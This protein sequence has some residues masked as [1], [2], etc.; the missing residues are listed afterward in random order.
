MNG[1]PAKIRART[2]SRTSARAAGPIGRLG[3]L[4][5][6]VVLGATA[7][8]CDVG[9]GEGWVRSDLLAVPDCWSG[10]FDLQPDFFGTVPYRDTQQIRIQRG[11]DQPEVSDG[12]AIQVNATGAIREQQLGQALDVG[13]SPELWSD[14][15]PTAVP[16]PAPLVNLALY[17]QFSCHNQNIVLYGVGGTVTFSA[18]FSGDPIESSGSEKLTEASFDVQVADPRDAPPGS[19]E[20]P[21]EKLTPLQGYFRFHFVRGQPAQPFP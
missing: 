4:L 16:G 5:A 17:L 2:A 12:V 14:I 1:D 19:T 18:L 8:G 7:T 10:P 11:S 3:H 20:I 21:A 15:N 6:A 9:Q 13:L